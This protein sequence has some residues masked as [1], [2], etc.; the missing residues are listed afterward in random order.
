[1]QITC[2]GCERNAHGG[3]VS[4]GEKAT[5]EDYFFNPPTTVTDRRLISQGKLTKTVRELEYFEPAFV[6]F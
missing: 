6:R 2:L 1:M 5:R 3:E 4:L